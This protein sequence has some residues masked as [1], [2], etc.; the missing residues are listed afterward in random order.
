MSVYIKRLYQTWIA[1]VFISLLGMLPTLSQ[2]APTVGMNGQKLVIASAVQVRQQPLVT[3]D[4]LTRLKLG[5]VVH[6]IERTST[7]QMIGNLRAYWYLVEA[8]NAKGWV[9]GQY[10]RDFVSAK[11][12]SSWLQLAR[13]RANNA[14]LSFGDY[15]DTYGF[16]SS[17]LPQIK[18]KAL[19]VEFE[20]N[21]LI[22]LQQS[23]NRIEPT[24]EKIQPFKGWLADRK[25]EI[26][27]DEISGQWLVPVDTYWQ[28]ANRVPNSP[29]G[30]SIAHYAA[31]APLGGECEDDIACGLRRVLI[32]DGEYLKRYPQGGYAIAS[33]KAIN[34]VLQGIQSS[35][36]QQPNYFR[37]DADSGK[38]LKALITI[39]KATK[40]THSA[41]V[42]TQLQAIQAQYNR[43]H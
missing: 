13:E 4:V 19:K 2:A 5:T 16:I 11:A 32:T 37:N 29:L 18:T 40:T 1:L 43:F 33:V 31:N 38:A 22:A 25:A 36:K 14:Q 21:R 12:E 10:L 27:H 28:L 41:K 39:I 3:A 9:F 20:F 15:A 17:V 24:Q 6:A 34:D 26:F 23:L 30:D 8:G 7:E 42:L 35:L